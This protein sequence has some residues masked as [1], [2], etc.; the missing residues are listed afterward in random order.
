MSSSSKLYRNAN[1]AHCLVLRSVGFLCHFLLNIF[2]NK[3]KICNCPPWREWFD[4]CMQFLSVMSLNL[5]GVYFCSNL[6]SICS[7]T[8]L[9]ESN[10]L[11][12]KFG[13]LFSFDFSFFSPAYSMPLQCHHFF[14]E[15]SSFIS[16][17]FFP[18]TAVYQHQGNI[19]RTLRF[20]I[21]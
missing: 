16:E 12:M 18:E 4:K 17:I 19:G 3:V 5:I 15:S 10:N 9:P 8:L 20:N 2:Q 11:L 6:M 1:F 13:N 14:A 21:V 7:F